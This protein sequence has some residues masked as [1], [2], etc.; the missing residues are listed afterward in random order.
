MI[1]PALAALSSSRIVCIIF[2]RL[3]AVFAFFNMSKITFFCVRVSDISGKVEELEAGVQALLM[4]CKT[5][6][7]LPEET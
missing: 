7:V 3:A 6:L 2:L 5:Q 1:L 4:T